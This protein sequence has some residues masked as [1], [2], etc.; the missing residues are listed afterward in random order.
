MSKGQQT[1]SLTI[2]SWTWSLSEEISNFVGSSKRNKK[3]YMDSNK[4]TGYDQITD[5]DLQ[6][7]VSKYIVTPTYLIKEA[8]KF[9]HVSV[10]WNVS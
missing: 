3:K 7:F 5:W 4:S 1:E 2:C 9:K 10:T 6:D 8:L